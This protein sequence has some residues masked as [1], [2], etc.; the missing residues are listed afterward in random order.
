MQT[1]IKC[2]HL[3]M[4]YE[5]K[6]YK[7]YDPKDKKMIVSRYVV[8]EESKGWNWSWKSQQQTIDGAT[9][10]DDGERNFHERHKNLNT[11]EEV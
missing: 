2:V 10:T 11:F 8:F 5:C 3:S 1:N 4:F 9:S 6:A 7:L